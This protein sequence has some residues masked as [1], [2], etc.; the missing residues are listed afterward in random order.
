[1][2]K[3]TRLGGGL[4]IYMDR[5]WYSSGNGE[6]V[7]VVLYSTEKFKPSTKGKGT[8]PLDIQNGGGGGGDKKIMYKAN[9]G[10]Q[11]GKPIPQIKGMNNLLAG[12]KV[13]IP[14]EMI[15]YVT[16]WGLD[17]IWLSAPTPSDNSPKPAN[18]REPAIVMNGVSLAEVP[19]T[20]R[21]TVIGYEPKYDE[22]RQLWYCDIELN[23]GESYYPFV[24]LGLC[25]LQ[26]NSLSKPETGED[27][28]CSRVTQSE[29]CQL[30]PDR[31]ATARVEDDRQS[32]TVQV[33]GHTYRTNAT[34]QTGSEMEVTIEKR[35]SGAG[36]DDLGWEPVVTQRIDRLPAA[37][38]W[39][40]LLKVPDSV[41][42]VQYRV[43]IKE[44]EQFFSD[45]LDTKERE[46]SL[47]DKSGGGDV[48][49]ELDRR[50]VYADVL[51]LY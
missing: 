14:E 13:D 32:V 34:G 18:F 45:P 25:R 11:G 26:P 37:D 43:V 20:Q 30:A 1:M 50:I 23:P 40:G 10:N 8:K 46:T 28:Y 31:E 22:E 51:P 29:F 3:S 47:G 36:S 21:F 38:L 27:V 2:I 15:T 9:T 44:Y 5:P 35:A 12:T 17:P 19:V 39:G 6:L 49:M 41:D 33:V 24:R 42:S 16:Q 48:K 4:R 7:G